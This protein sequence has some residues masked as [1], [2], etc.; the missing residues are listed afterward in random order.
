MGWVEIRWDRGKK[1]GRKWERE[2]RK[3]GGRRGE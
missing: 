1:Q 3:K 2:Q